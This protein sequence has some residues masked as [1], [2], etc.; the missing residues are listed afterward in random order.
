MVVIS[1]IRPKVLRTRLRPV[2]D[3]F[4][5]FLASVRARSRTPSAVF[6]FGPEIQQGPSRRPRRP[7][8]SIFQ[9]PIGGVIS[10]GSSP[11]LQMAFWNGGK[12]QALRPALPPSQ[13]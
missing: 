1:E 7:S 11:D 4:I 9:T 3:L 6:P 5:A 12:R 2:K 8:R 13:S 10:G